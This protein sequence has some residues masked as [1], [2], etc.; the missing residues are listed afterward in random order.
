MQPLLKQEPAFL[1]L[2]DRSEHGFLGS[3]LGQTASLHNVVESHVIFTLLAMRPG[4][5]EVRE[6]YQLFIRELFLVLEDNLQNLD[7]RVGVLYGPVAER[8]DHTQPEVI[9]ER[10]SAAQCG[11]ESLQE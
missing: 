8:S 9:P 10:H 1:D 6:G 2:D 11:R 7:G 5:P 4:L 3:L